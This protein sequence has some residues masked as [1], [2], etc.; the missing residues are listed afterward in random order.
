M[1]HKEQIP[2]KRSERRRYAS[3]DE[4]GGWGR[5]QEGVIGCAYGQNMLHTCMDVM[6]KP[7][8]V[9]NSYMLIES[10]CRYP[11]DTDTLKVKLGFYI[12]SH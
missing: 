2:L 6:T 11:K 5:G 3:S 9:Y 7:I 1:G 10:C 12:S 4:E 8:V